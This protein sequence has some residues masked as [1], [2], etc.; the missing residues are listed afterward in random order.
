MGYGKG[1]IVGWLSASQSDF[2]NERTKRPAALWH[3][4]FDEVC[5]KHNRYSPSAMGEEDLE[6]NEIK[7][8][9]ASFSNEKDSP[10]WY[11]FHVCVLI[12]CGGVDLCLY[13]FRL[14]MRSGSRLAPDTHLA[15]YT[16]CTRI[17][18]SLVPSHLPV[19]CPPAGRF[20][21]GLLFGCLA[22]CTSANFPSLWGKFYAPPR[23]T[24]CAFGHVSE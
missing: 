17:C 20:A 21:Y 5:E 14:D 15:Q 22:G 11:L 12:A 10:A 2:V 8:A 24:I 13:T 1:K 18:L 19:A 23:S 16:S 3:V 9:V 4:V 7:E 6:E